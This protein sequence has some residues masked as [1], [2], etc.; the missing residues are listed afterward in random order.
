MKRILKFFTSIKLAIVLLI[1]LAAA[2][3]LGTLIPQDRSLEEY[4]ARYGTLSTLFVRLQ[5]TGLYHSI[6]YLTLLGLVALNI[7]VCT[8]ERLSPKWRRAT[9][10]HITA[11]AKS[12]SALKTN[13]RIKRSAPLADVQSE[14]T[15]L[16]AGAHYKVRTE[17]QGPRIAVLA[18]KRI[19]G[20][21]GSDAVHLGLL[22]ILAGG[23]LSGVTS[24]RE[25]IPLYE[26]DI[27][28]V[29]KADFKVRLDKF[30]TEY[31]PDG[32]VK[33]WKSDLTV[34]EKKTPVLS[35]TI[36]VNHPLTYKGYSF[37]QT[38]YGWNWD[39]PAVEIWAKSKSD[40][41]YL[42]K[43]T[44][45]VGDRALLEDKGQTTIAVQRFLPDFVLGESNQPENRSDQPNNPAALI[46]GFRGAEKVFSGWIF[47]NYPD[48]AQMHAANDKDKGAET[49]LA[50]ELKKFEAG[51]FSVLEAAKDPGANLIWIGCA[52]LMLGLGL[53]FY[54][55][56]WEIKA[57]LEESQGK[58]DLVAGGVAAKSREAFGA[59]FENIAA[60][61]RRSK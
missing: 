31:Y 36:A 7:I 46:E 17:T 40:P 4:A 18:R 53:A 23:I 50:F 8:L 5:L 59:E 47:A 58:T 54:W 42:K 26:G 20:I 1:I 3:I 28:P 2:S 52:L 9:K 43:M 10:P 12:L 55:P 13:V 49:D 27:K 60:A 32:S 14:V 61:L 35:K 24:V 30:T 51:Q 39:S 21:F 25:N 22:I 15:K 34:L 16:L 33:A 48:F 11:D 56:T 19:G 6:W 29:L 37:Y 57:V 44:L 41:A 45:K 38:S